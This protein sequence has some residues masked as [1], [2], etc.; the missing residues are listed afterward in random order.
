MHTNKVV[1]IREITKHKFS[2]RKW[3]TIF[4]G[5][6]QVPNEVKEPISLTVGGSTKSVISEMINVGLKSDST[7][8]NYKKVK[9]KWNYCSDNTVAFHNLNKTEKNDI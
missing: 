8:V 2:C 4:S 6:F 5:L 1:Y 7:G 9:N 3:D